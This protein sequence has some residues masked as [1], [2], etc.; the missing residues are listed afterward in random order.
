MRRFITSIAL[1]GAFFIIPSLEVSASWLIDHERFHTSVHG[2]MDCLECHQDKT[3]TG[4]H[5]DPG[6]VNKTVHAFFNVEQCVDCHDSA[7]EELESGNH[8]NGTGKVSKEDSSCIQCHDP[9]TTMSSGSENI[10]FSAPVSEKCAVCHEVQTDLPPVAAQEAV[11][12]ECHLI[13]IKGTDKRAAMVQDLCFYCHGTD[14]KTGH[15]PVIDV[16]A[17]SST[18]HSEMSCL[19]CHPFSAGFNHAGQPTADCKTCHL[20]HNK[21]TIRDPHVTVSC[22]ACHLEGAWAVR[23]GLTGQILGKTV[24][25]SETQVHHMAL[26]D[27]ETSCSRCHF[28]GNSVGAAAHILP[29]K[30][31]FCMPCH[32]ATLSV[33]DTVSMITLILF[34]LGIAVL[35][36]YLFTGSRLAGQQG[37]QDHGHTK[38]SGIKDMIKVMIVEG[39]FQRRLFLRSRARWMI[40]SLIFHAFLFRFFWGL[41][42]LAASSWESQWGGLSFMLNKNDSI[43]ALVFDVTGCMMLLGLIL[44]VFLK[45]SKMKHINFDGFPKLDWPA[46]ILLGGL[47][48]VG[49]VLEGLR[50]AMTG[51]PPGAEYALVGY[52]IGWI[53]PDVDFTV[54]Y[55]WIWYA[56]AILT[57]C[58]VVYLP[59]SRLRHIVLVPLALAI[60]ANSKKGHNRRPPQ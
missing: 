3:G 30:G 9:H 52:F 2:Q 31:V 39:L 51:S 55:G 28:R 54:I 26:P 15:H 8:G 25:S 27:D 14:G 29:A 6:S 7:L 58:L 10:D 5:P 42:A 20:S 23:D 50:I 18:P 59:F 33:E 56:H 34:A 16:P 53:L 40:H 19:T 48:V 49:F 46:F 11:C 37:Q 57:G 22:E 44:F 43:T 1:L 35:G 21:K 32:S 24:K 12:A 41:F 4:D 17:Y 45:H 36:T 47:I 38:G 60:T 13:P